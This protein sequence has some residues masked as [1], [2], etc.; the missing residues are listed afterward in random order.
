MKSPGQ[1]LCTLL[2]AALP[3]DGWPAEIQSPHMHMI[4]ENI[5]TCL[6]VVDCSRWV[7]SAHVCAENTD[8]RDSSTHST[9]MRSDVV[10]Y[11]PV[12]I[13]GVAYFI[14]RFRLCRLCFSHP[15]FLILLASCSVP[16]VTH[17][18]KSH[19]KK[20]FAVTLGGA[21]RSISHLEPQRGSI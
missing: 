17:G 19:P 15:A 13:P 7:W 5:W 8:E 9:G 21:S 1:T 20:Q 14:W 18:A 3:H 10:Y 11:I 6:S 16:P 4:K 12:M 2:A